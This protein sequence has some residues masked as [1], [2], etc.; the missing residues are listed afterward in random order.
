MQSKISIVTAVYNGERFL[1]RFLKSIEEQTNDNFELIIID[2]GSSDGSIQII[3]EYSHLVDFW[4][5]EPDKGIYDA[6]N[7]GVKKASGE[8]I[9]F[10]GS[11][12]MLKP[13]GIET[14]V[15]FM[16]M[17]KDLNQIEYISSKVQ[18][19]DLEG[20][21]IRIKGWPWEW[22]KFLKEMTVAHPGSLHSKRL[23]EKYGLFDTG[24]KITGDY[25][26]LLRPKSQL[27]SLYMPHV[28]VLMSEGGA[29][30]SIAS[31]KE[32]TRASIATGG[33]STYQASL[34]F[35]VIYIKFTLKKF[36]RRFGLNLY[37]KR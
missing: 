19:I 33:A 8:W 20:K 31:V 2:G 5:S 6:W 21:P 11:D 9:M 23:F 14:Y 30:D 15:K 7:K 32:Q 24:Y 17:Q 22:P 18:M 4:I 1:R 10:I 16:S 29:S 12:D 25:E 13:D 34:N 26:L 35:W 3:N 36:F 27:K 37:I 28:T